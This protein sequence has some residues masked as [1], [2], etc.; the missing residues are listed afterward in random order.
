M[1]ETKYFSTCR[2]TADN[3]MYKIQ[4]AK[5]GR[6]PKQPTKVAHGPYFHCVGHTFICWVQDMTSLIPRLPGNEANVCVQ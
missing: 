6:M 1:I 2:E 5:R 3:V 4:K